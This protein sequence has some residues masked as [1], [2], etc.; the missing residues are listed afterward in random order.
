MSRSRRERRSS[1]PRARCGPR[2]ACGRPTSPRARRATSPRTNCS[3]F[4]EWAGCMLPSEYEWERAARGDRLN[5]QQFTGDGRWDHNTEPGIV[6]SGDN[7]AAL[8]GPLPVDVGTVRKSDSP[9]GLRH[10]LGNVWELTR[11]L[12]GLPP[13]AE[14]APPPP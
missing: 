8:P 4:A 3:T 11:T 6:S 10:M 9:F 13:R 2:R 14:P 7:P 5:S 1:F 12:L